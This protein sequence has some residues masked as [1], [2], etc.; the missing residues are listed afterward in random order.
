MFD[1]EIV[2]F[3]WVLGFRQQIF[4]AEFNPQMQF[5]CIAPD[6]MH[7]SGLLIRNRTGAISFQEVPDGLKWCQDKTGSW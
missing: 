7:Y 4:R 3:L 1:W 6:L 2:W 5:R